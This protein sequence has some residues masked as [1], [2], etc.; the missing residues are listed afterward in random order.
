MNV[1][2]QCSLPALGMRPKTI[3]F[4][5]FRFEENR[6]KSRKIVSQELR[7]D[8]VCLCDLCEHQL[9]FHF[10]VIRTSHRFENAHEIQFRVSGN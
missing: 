3:S 4:Q 5:G 8:A 9:W 10:I 1:Y 2:I 7:S 6:K